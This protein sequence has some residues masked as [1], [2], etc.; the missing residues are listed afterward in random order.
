MARTETVG[1]SFGILWVVGYTDDTATGNV[2]ILGPPDC[3]TW[4][5]LSLLTASHKFSVDLDGAY[6]YYSSLKL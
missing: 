3:Q 5:E 4:G 6:I 2:E 1:S